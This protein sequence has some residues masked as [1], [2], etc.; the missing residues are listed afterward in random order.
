M[1]N[2]TIKNWLDSS[3]IEGHDIYLVGGTVRDL[4]MDRVPKDLD[5]VCRDAG[6]FAAGLAAMKNAALVVLEKNPHQPCF[7]VVDREDAG[8][9]LDITEMRGTTIH[10]DLM[11]RDFTINAIAI[12]INQDGSTGEVIDPMRGYADIK[13]G[14]IRM[15]S[16]KAIF[17]D[18][19]RAVRAVRF[20]AAFSFTQEES[21]LNE[22]KLRAPML[23]DVSAERIMTELMLILATP[24]SSLFFMQM[25]ELGMLE[26]IFPG[27]IQMKGCG[28]NGYHHKDVWG[29]SLLVMQHAE[30]IINNLDD[31]FGERS[32]DVLQNL[33]S[34][35]RLPLL[36]LAALLHDIGKPDTK[37]TDPVTGRISFHN[38]AARGAATIEVLSQAMKMSCENIRFLVLLIAEHLKILTLASGRTKPATQMRW[39]RKM[40]DDAIPAI[41]LS[42]ADMMSILGPEAGED[43]RQNHL[44]WSKKSI[45]KYYENIRTRIEKKPLITGS[46]LIALGMAPGPGIGK[47]LGQ[48]RD[49]QDTDEVTTREA[50]LVL[51][52]SLVSRIS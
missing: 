3:S 35:S 41:I 26:I 21:T 47:V 5:L 14:T 43:Y 24:H 40:H 32:E 13:K 1:H 36:K 34:A 8:N 10:D 4:L 2:L 46:D 25:D 45:I 22:M 9:Y 30:H 6:K 50:A 39:F 29:H 17:S 15:V 27:I 44:D 33:A 23:R 37:D 20:G 7:R 48:V 19:L 51:A 18:P 52:R 38:H 11:E 49:A 42:M 31:Y 28:Q 12:K 16:E